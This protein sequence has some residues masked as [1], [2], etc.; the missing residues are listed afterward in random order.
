IRTAT[1]SDRAAEALAVIRETVRQ[2]AEEGPT[3]AELEAAKK[4]IVGSYALSN[5]GT[6]GAIASTLLSLQQEGLGI[7]YMRRRDALINSV[8][9]DDVK[10][11]ARKLLS[12]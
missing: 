7:D 2:M 5:L 6:S 8:T 11:A 10:A 12:A 3:D 1:R 4:Y 9:L